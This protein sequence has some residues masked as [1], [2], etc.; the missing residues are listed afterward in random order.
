MKGKINIL[1]KI[2]LLIYIAYLLIDKL[3]VEVP[4]E[5]AIPVVIFGV[6]LIIIGTV[7]THRGT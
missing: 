4:Y 2:G 6:A 7:K 1:T 5:I 3:I